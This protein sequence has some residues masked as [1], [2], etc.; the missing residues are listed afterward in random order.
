M[1]SSHANECSN[2]ECS[3]LSGVRILVVEDS[4]Q[5]GIAVKNLLNAWGAEV[6]GPV[7]TCADAQRLASEQAPDA[8]LVDFT[9]RGGEQAAGL[10]DQLH[11]QGVHVV[12]TSG[13]P[14]LPVALRHAAAILEKPL[15][16]AELIGSLRQVVARK[17]Q[18]S[19]RTQRASSAV[20]SDWRWS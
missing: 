4:C 11:D 8:A 10:V 18:Q 3:D 20:P 9:L 2:I 19:S 12:V 6:S 7:A 17:A 1:D 14:V 5:V 16:E 15:R 13:Y